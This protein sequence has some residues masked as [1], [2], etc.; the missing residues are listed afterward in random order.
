[1][2]PAQALEE[3]KRGDLRPVYLVFGDERF[4]RDQVIKELRAAALGSGIAAFNEDR[5]TAGE[6]DVSKVI[7]AARTV[8][9]MAPRRFVM[10]SSLERW[11]ASEGDAA[12]F[13]RLAEYVQAPIAE[14]CLVLSAGKLDGRRRLAAIAKKQGFAVDCTPLD[15]RELPHW[16]SERARGLGHPIEHEVADLLAELVGPELGPVAD[17][18]ERLSLYVGPG[19]PLSEAA[20]GH[21][22]TRIRAQDTWAVVEAVR[23]RNLAAGLKALADAFDPRDRGLPLLG[24]LAWSLRQLARFQAELAGGASTEEAAKRAGVFQPFRAR[25]LGKL[26]SAVPSREV[27][28]WLLVLSE[29][30][31]AL[32]GS[33][34][35][36]DAVLEEMLTRLCRPAGPAASK[37]ASR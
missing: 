9:M 16:I 3:A 1:M 27:E 15:R 19:E 34:R 11:E 6:A 31:L 36:P 5:F 32:K 25:E 10:V 26:A 33:R 12:P 4:L 22:I 18:L 21:T 13:D 2:T 7:A 17:A 24:A 20:V 35:P 28:R 29:A 14:T 37:A 30:D 23:N 8:P